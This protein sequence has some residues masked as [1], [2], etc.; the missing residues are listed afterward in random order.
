MNSKDKSLAGAIM[1]S[2]A[3]FA[4]FYFVLPS[5]DQ[6]KALNKAVAGRK[7]LLESRSKIIGQI[8]KLREE[9]NANK[10]GLDKISI[11]IPSQKHIPELIS[12]LE[13]MAGSTGVA[14][15]RLNIGGTPTKETDEVASLP[16]TVKLTGSYQSY[17]NFLNLI[18]AN[19]R[20]INIGLSKASLNETSGNL[21][22]D[23]SGRTY[24][25][26]KTKTNNE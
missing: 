16:V 17:K 15:T 1:L 26:S 13:S 9:Y 23:L 14:L 21:T 18:E 4:F 8:L 10:E 12:A 25:L 22:I 20:L 7:D 19:R 5:Y 6:T 24:I 3:A 11:I 2:A